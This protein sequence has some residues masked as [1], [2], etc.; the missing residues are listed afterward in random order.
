MGLKQRQAHTGAILLDQASFSEGYAFVGSAGVE[1]A[2]TVG[3]FHRGSD[4]SISSRLPVAWT[5]G[6]VDSP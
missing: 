4:Q 5:G 2:K 6:L 1:S 3:P